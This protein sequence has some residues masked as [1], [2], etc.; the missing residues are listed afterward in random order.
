M[1]RYR[2][3]LIQKTPWAGVLSVRHD[4][5]C[6][7]NS[8]DRYHL[9]VPNL[10]VTVK[11]AEQGSVRERLSEERRGNRLALPAGL[12]F[13]IGLALGLMIGNSHGEPGP[14][15]AYLI[16]AFGLGSLVPLLWQWSREQ[17]G[18]SAGTD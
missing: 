7:G 2:R 10:E 16:I 11:S 6:G 14:N 15:W 13:V 1:S 5:V 12:S 3:W 18:T 9:C 4:K 17:R 8:G